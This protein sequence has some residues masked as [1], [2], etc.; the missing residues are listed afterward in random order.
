MFFIQRNIPLFHREKHWSHDIFDSKHFFV[1]FCFLFHSSENGESKGWGDRFRQASVR[2]KVG[3]FLSLVYET[4]KQQKAT[5]GVCGSHLVRDFNPYAYACGLDASWRRC[6]HRTCGK[7][8]HQPVEDVLFAC[9]LMSRHEVVGVTYASS[10]QPIPIT[11]LVTSSL[12]CLSLTSYCS[13][14]VCVL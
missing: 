4:K 3:I 8:S 2:I 10:A 9:L 7:S 13:R 14:W 11:Q 12:P 6:A 1:D 5:G